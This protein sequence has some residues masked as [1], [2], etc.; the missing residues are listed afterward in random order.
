MEAWN[1]V[2]FKWLVIPGRLEG[3]SPESDERISLGVLPPAIGVGEAEEEQAA[4]KPRRRTRKPRAE[5]GDD[6]VAPAA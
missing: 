2:G 1:R 4:A 3:A 6:E 5:D